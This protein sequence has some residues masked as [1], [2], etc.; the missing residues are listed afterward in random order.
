MN[1]KQ[2]QE[3]IEIVNSKH[4][5]TLIIN[6]VKPGGQVSINPNNIRVSIKECCAAVINELVE[7]GFS[8][9]M[10]EGML[11]VDNYKA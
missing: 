8:C 1:P 4:S 6:H 10:H 5:T 11:Q 9:S 7:K 2:F 3:L